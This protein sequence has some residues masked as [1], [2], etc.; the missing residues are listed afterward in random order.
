MSKTTKKKHVVKEALEDFFIPK[1]NQSIVKVLCSKGNN[2]HEVQTSIGEQ[3]LVSMPTKFRK[4][5]WIKRGDY[6]VVEP[7]EEGDKVKGEIVSLLFKEQ[8]K[9]IKSEG[10][11]PQGF[12]E[13]QIKPMER[14]EPQSDS[15]SDSDLFVN[16]NRPVQIVSSS[17]DE[18]DSDE[19][20]SW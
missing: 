11:W 6:V 2:L 3:F 17:E 16:T 15:D 18:T 19:S 10:L 13:E 7:I 14:R 20:D 12:E 8:V 9:H 1:E 4:N 5:I